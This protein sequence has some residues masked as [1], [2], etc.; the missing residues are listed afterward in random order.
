[1]Q[2]TLKYFL[3]DKKEIKP[4]YGSMKLIF[5]SNIKIIESLPATMSIVECCLFLSTIFHDKDMKLIDHIL[6]SI[7]ENALLSMSMKFT[8]SSLVLISL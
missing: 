4:V 3:S 7:Q 5:R 1:M 8:I 2:T 6:V